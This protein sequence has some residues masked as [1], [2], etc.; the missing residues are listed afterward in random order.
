[1]ADPKIDWPSPPPDIAFADRSV[2]AWAISLNPTN[3]VLSR[4]KTLLSPDESD[5]AV[6]FKFER[7]QRRFA[8]AHAALRD[9]LSRY[10]GQPHETLRF[11]ATPR[12]KPERFM[13]LA[14]VT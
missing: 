2:H 14:G 12:G 5:R 1:M 6:R 13:R 3:E 9:I 10:T 8:V 4:C 11:V 7:D